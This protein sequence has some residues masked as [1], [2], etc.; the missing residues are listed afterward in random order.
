MNRLKLTGLV[1]A[2][3]TPFHD[4]GSL[5]LSVVEQQAELRECS[6]RALEVRF[7]VPPLPYRV[8]EKDEK[9]PLAETFG[10]KRLGR[11]SP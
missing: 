7:Q 4:D 6:V 1:A 3:H 2:T 8:F 5:N 9:V 11:R 10:N